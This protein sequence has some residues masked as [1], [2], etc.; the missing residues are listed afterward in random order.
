MTTEPPLQP[1]PTL[2]TNS[3][4][5]KPDSAAKSHMLVMSLYTLTMLASAGLLFL[6]QPMFARMVLP[7][8]G[9][10]PSVWN[11]ALVLYQSLLL[12]GYTYAYAVNR[13]L[14]VRQQIL[15]HAF[16]LLLPLIVIPIHLPQ[17]WLPPTDH[18]PL[19]WLLA[20]LMIA[21]GLPF[22]VVSTSSPLLQRWFAASGH[23][24]ALD[25]YF[26]YGAS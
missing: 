5:L 15:L 3:Q 24:L 21:V 4:I 17:G 11:T 9:G 7:L 20:V 22:F 13:W 8:L 26:L 23:P 6:V 16:V 2:E 10:S 19:L 25:P 12:A 18:S 14:S 1:S